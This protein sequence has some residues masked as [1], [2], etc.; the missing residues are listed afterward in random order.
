M[1]KLKKIIIIIAAGFFSLI[2]LFFS[3]CINKTSSDS[4]FNLASIKF[5]NEDKEVFEIKAEVADTI[6]KQTIG[7]M[8]REK[9]DEDRG[10]FFVFNSEGKRDFWMKNT[11]IP[12][13]MVFLDKDLKI[14]N[15]IENAQPCKV[16]DCEIYSSIDP[17]RYVIEINGG[18]SS[19]YNLTNQTKVIL[20]K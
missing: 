12:L 17:A 20:E 8:N 3:G 5:Y 6:Y 2:F 9:L 18:L 4:N 16:L 13:D 7:L 14:I 19:K 10:M 11:L 15:I 1:N